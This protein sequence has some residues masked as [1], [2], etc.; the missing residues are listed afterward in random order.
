MGILRGDKLFHVTG[1][2]VIEDVVAAA[3]E[4]NGAVDIK[5]PNGKVEAMGTFHLFNTRTAADIA[6]ANRKAPTPKHSVSPPQI[7]SNPK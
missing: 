7:I 1:S 6:S 4:R 5:Y 2:G 3:D